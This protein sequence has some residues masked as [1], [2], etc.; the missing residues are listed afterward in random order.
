MLLA[1]AVPLQRS[2]LVVQTLWV[3]FRTSEAVHVWIVLTAKSS[4]TVRAAG[5]TGLPFRSIY[6][7]RKGKNSLVYS[8]NITHNL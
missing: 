1:M 2:R 8:K 3:Q 4:V 5:E 7:H 6:L